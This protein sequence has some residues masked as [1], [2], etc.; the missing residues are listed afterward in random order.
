MWGIVQ[1]NTG[2]THSKWGLVANLGM[3]LPPI[4]MLL[5]ALS[6]REKAEVTTKDDNLTDIRTSMGNKSLSV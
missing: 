5:F 1:D 3:N 2:G 4:I 6:F